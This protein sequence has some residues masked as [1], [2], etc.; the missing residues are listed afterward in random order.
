MGW[1]K[2]RQIDLLRSTLKMSKYLVLLYP[3]II[4]RIVINEKKGDA[5]LSQLH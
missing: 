3:Q 1:R 2:H 5:T 4:N